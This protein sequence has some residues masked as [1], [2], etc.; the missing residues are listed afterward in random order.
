M[1]SGE[2]VESLGFKDEAEFHALVG[3]V[4]C[5]SSSK[6]DA[7][8]RWQHKDGTK[9]GLLN[10]PTLPEQQVWLKMK[11]SP[12]YIHQLRGACYISWVLAKDKNEALKFPL[13]D[14]LKWVSVLEKMSGVDLIAV[15]CPK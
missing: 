8:K 10:L 13:E 9:E 12:M 6:F 1:I 15:D 4:D 2:I 7:F 14:A 5:H 3:K 11:Y